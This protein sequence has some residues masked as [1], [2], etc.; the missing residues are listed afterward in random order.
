MEQVWR[1]LLEAQSRLEG[2]GIQSAVIG[3][4]AVAVWGLP[5]ATQ[6][7][8]VLL[9]RAQADRLLGTLFPQG[10]PAETRTFLQRNGILFASRTAGFESTTCS[11]T[12]P[13]TDRRSSVGLRRWWRR[14]YGPRSARPR[15]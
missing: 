14:R 4:I 8:E 3:G 11:L 10:C 9:T 15:T 6:D 7:V 13:L 2:A 12:R 1:A 5:R